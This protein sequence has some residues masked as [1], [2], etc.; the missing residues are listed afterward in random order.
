MTA[1]SELTAL[2]DALIQL[3][4]KFDTFEKNNAEDKV[5]IAKLAEAINLQQNQIKEI[6][7]AVDEAAKAFQSLGEYVKIKIPNISP[8]QPQNSWQGTFQEILKIV[9][10]AI[11]P[12]N[13]TPD[14]ASL[15]F[16]KQMDEISKKTQLLYAKA[17]LKDA[18]KFEKTPIQ[19]IKIEENP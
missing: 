9:S 7:G 15:A 3:K 12:E 2:T 4:N 1:N 8:E 11:N 19:H 6:S 14:V 13:P 18:E 16:Q 10:K 5:N 17:A